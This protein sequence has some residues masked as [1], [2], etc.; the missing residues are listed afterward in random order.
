MSDFT[1]PTRPGLVNS[2]GT[3]DALFLKLFGGEVLLAFMESNVILSRHMVRTIPHGKSAAFPALG[4]GTASYHTPGAEIQGTQVHANER[5]IVIDDLLIAPRFIANIDEAK[6]HWD[7][8]SGISRDIGMALA[9]EFDQNVL[10]VGVNAARASATVSGGNGGTVI[11]AATADTDADALV[12]A[13]F[14]A[15]QAFDEKDVPSEDR[16]FFVKP[17]QYYLLVSSTSKAINRDYGN[18][19]NG[20][21]AGG[22]I[23]RVAGM[24]IVKTNN[25]PQTNVVSG[26]TAY[27]GNFTTTI[28]LA[29]QKQ[30]VGTVKLMDLAMEMEYS[31]RHQGTLLVGK[32]ALGSDILR[33]ECAV[34][35]KTA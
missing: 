33:P 3:A 23:L 25:L 16:Y 31:A 14:D 32:Y 27:Q 12:A 1:A 22:F 24:E 2:A 34:E 9:R 21:I 6:V 8:R 29:M 18:E 15:A 17:E 13:I 30:A 35:V 10:R 4:K 20:S 19:G 11:T 26:P 28:G 7:Y 5:V